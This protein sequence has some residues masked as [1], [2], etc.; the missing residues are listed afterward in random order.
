MENL[1][2]SNGQ[3]NG[4]DPVTD[5]DMLRGIA[6]RDPD[7]LARLYDRFG[8]ILFSLASRWLNDA[9]DSEEVTQDVF[10]S[11]WTHPLRYRSARSSPLTWLAA[12]TRHKCIDRCGSPDA[13]SLV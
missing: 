3:R 6:S 8:R 4:A 10:L 12:I 2:A 9:R 5:M 13:A 11:V 7:S 1:S